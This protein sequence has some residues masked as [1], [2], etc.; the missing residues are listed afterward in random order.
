MTVERLPDVVRLVVRDDGSGLV[1]GAATANGFG[2][3]AMRERVARLG[4]S[5]RFTS[6]AG[7]GTEVAVEVPADARGRT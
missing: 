3:A 6:G 4:G 7:P 2:T 1:P 5:L